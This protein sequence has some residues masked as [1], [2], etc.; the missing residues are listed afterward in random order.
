MYLSFNLI[1]SSFIFWQHSEHFLVE[2]GKP[3]GKSEVDPSEIS[4]NEAEQNIGVL[5]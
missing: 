2:L 4:G 3:K 5:S 1:I